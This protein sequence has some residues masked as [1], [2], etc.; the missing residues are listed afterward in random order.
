MFWLVLWLSVTVVIC[1][2][3]ILPLARTPLHTRL[4]EVLSRGWH[5]L[6]P[7]PPEAPGPPIEDIAAS[8][9]RCQRWLDMYADPRPIPGKA[10]KLIAAADA[11]DRV[12]VAACHA[13]DVPEDLE[14]TEGLDREAERLRM[15]AALGDAGFILSG[16]RQ[17]ER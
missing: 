7:R 10:T 14:H 3:A 16:R 1:A 15:Q 17:A 11:Y 4:A 2:T 6:R 12:L 13:L 8:L 5:H 9:H